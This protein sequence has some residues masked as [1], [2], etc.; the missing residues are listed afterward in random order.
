MQ[1]FNTPII[2]ATGD[3]G[4]ILPAHFPEIQEKS[5]LVISSFFPPN[6]PESD[7]LTKMM[8][9]C[10]L[11]PED[12]AIMW[13]Q[14][15]DVLSW[16]MLKTAG[17]PDRVLILGLHPNQL[18]IHSLFPLN[19]CQDFAEGK[20]IFGSSLSEIVQNSSTKRALWDQGLKPCFG[21]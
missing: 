2:S 18:G 17:V 15:G 19:V 3:A 5:M 7:T 20:I 8:T 6:S 13:L 12:Y 11:T 10:K 16:Q 1:L 21:L 14:E 9:A 4:W